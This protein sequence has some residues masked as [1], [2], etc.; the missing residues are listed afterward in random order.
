[1]FHH[2]CWVYEDMC[3]SLSFQYL[4]KYK[5][6]KSSQTDAKFSCL[7]LKTKWKYMIW[8][9]WELNWDPVCVCVCL[10]AHLCLTLWGPMDWRPRGSSVHGDSPGK[11][12]GMGCH[13]L[14]QGIFPTQELN[15][16]LPHCRRILYYVSHQGTTRLLPSNACFPVQKILHRLEVGILTPNEES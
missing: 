15:P 7:E 4:I 2:N 11:N 10:F 13:T 12:A 1:M 16:G 8:I 6:W 3:S 5:K 14:L 9:K